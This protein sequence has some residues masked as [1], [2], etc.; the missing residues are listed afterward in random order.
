MIGISLG[1]CTS[2][3]LKQ[4]FRG[5][6]HILPETKHRALFD[7]VFKKFTGMFDV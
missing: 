1:E 4:G 3:S 7:V 2:G 5:F 6:C